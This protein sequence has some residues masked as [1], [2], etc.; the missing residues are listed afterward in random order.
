MLAKINV[1]TKIK[2][3]IFFSGNDKKIEHGALANR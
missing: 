2:S 1:V 3:G